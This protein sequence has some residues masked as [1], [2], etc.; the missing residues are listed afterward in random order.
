MNSFAPAQLPVENIH[1]DKK[2]PRGESEE[3]ILKDPEF[4]KLVSSIKEFGILEPLVVKEETK[5]KDTYVLIDG[6]RRLRAAKKISLPKA[7][8]IIA[9]SDTNG[10]VLAYQIHML[11]KQWEKASETKSIKS[12]IADL[13]QEN[14]KISDGDLK[15][16]LLEITKHKDH[17]I[18]DLMNLCKYD[19]VIIDKVL[20]DEL[21]MSYLIQNEKS[22]ITPLKRKYPD[23]V[24]TYTEDKIRKIMAQKALDS[25]LVKSRYL[26]DTFKYVF[27]DEKNHQK[28]KRIIKRFLNSKDKSIE[29][30]FNEYLETD[31]ALM[32]KFGLGHKSKSKS[33][34]NKPAAAHQL[35]LKT[36]PQ[37]QTKLAD[38]EK[39]FLRSSLTSEELAY[40]KEA[41][42]CMRAACLKASVVMIWATGISRIID[43]ISNNISKYNSAVDR[44][45][46][47][48][49]KKCKPYNYTHYRKVSDEDGLRDGNDYQL[50]N[51]LL[52]EK[53]IHMADYKQLKSA[54]DTRCDCAH[55]TNIDLKVNRVL[56]I[57]EEICNHIFL[58]KSIK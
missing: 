43:F 6:E 3:V 13:M 56:T 10:R 52:Y 14:P 20:R 30:A 15:K 16:K 57:F 8:A 35:I 32:K 27:R 28:I 58:N 47:L 18:D 26:M 7:P 12:I 41:F 36:T 4:E 44:M 53:I 48:A 55:P 5:Q 1:F 45:K 24:A 23:L 51:Y 49:D 9:D 21:D 25:K 50:L 54:Y 29:T 40:I 11:R 31:K 22:F 39:R 34:K 37:Q 33:T 46:E 2:N 19:D 38:I 42:S 17:E